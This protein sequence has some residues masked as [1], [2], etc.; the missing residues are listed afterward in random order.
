MLANALWAYVVM[1]FGIKVGNF[2]PKTYMQQVVENS[3]FR[4]YDDGLRMILDCTPELEQALTQRLADGGLKRHR[5]LWPAPAGRGDDDLLHAVGDAQRPRSL[6]RRRARRLCLGGDRVEG[7]GGLSFSP[8]HNAG[9]LLT[10]PS[11]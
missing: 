2:V 1:R 3:D 8:P 11:A 6:H 10:C 7:D 4:K 9:W 5:A